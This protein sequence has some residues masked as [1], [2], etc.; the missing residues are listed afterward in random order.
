ML[1]MGL[2][3]VLLAVP[4]VHVLVRPVT[5][6]VEAKE[7]ATM[8]AV[9]PTRP[10][11]QELLP[12]RIVEM[13]KRLERLL[14]PFFRAVVQRLTIVAKDPLLAETQFGELLLFAVPGE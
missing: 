10:L 2:M 11:G 7:H 9:Q 4:D 1:L 8:M 14:A 12:L 6:L 5:D 3:G 13:M